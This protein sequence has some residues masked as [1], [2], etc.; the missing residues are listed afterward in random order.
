MLT[1][2]RSAAT[3]CVA[4][5]EARGARR[6]CRRSAGPC[7]AGRSRPRPPRPGGSRET[8]GSGRA[9]R[10]RCRSRRR[11]AVPPCGEPPEIVGIARSGS[12]GAPPG[13]HGRR[14]RPATGG[15]RT[16][17]AGRR[18][19]V[20]GSE[21]RAS[22]RRWGSRTPGSRPDASAA[23][24]RHFRS[25]SARWRLAA[26][27]TGRTGRGARGGS[28]GFAP[29]ALAPRRPGAR[30]R[31]APPAE[32]SGPGYRPGAA[33]FGG[34]ALGQGEQRL[35][36]QDLERRAVLRSRPRLA[37]E[38]EG[39]ED[40][41]PPRRAIATRPGPAGIRPRRA[42][43]RERGARPA[44]SHSSAS[45]SSRPMAR[46]SAR[47]RSRSGMRWRTSSAA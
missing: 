41:E 47:R 8:R 29:P 19:R 40:G 44:L 10:S 37:L 42:G 32:D 45:H 2:S 27:T 21:A 43:D 6:G 15:A 23:S 5:V 1:R 20:G 11:E 4:V 38:V 31:S 16:R 24:A 35:R 39:A 12:P 7:P 22:I 26:A 34:L 3:S 33:G 28:G 36:A 14:R 30:R 46:S 13:S 9:H 18:D 25:A 17:P